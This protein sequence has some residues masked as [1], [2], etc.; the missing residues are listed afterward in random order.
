[1]SGFTHSSGCIGLRLGSA[2]LTAGA[3]SGTCENSALTASEIQVAALGSKI[4]NEDLKLPAST[5]VPCFYGLHKTVD[6][7]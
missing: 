6:C 7:Y 2:N 1:M 3:W 5:G 4:S